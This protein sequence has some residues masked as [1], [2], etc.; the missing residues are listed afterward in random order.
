MQMTISRQ[1]PTGVSTNENQRWQRHL[2]KVD[3]ISQKLAGVANRLVT[4]RL[5]TF[6]ALVTL[7]VSPSDRQL[8]FGFFGEVLI[9]LLVIAFGYQIQRH[10][11]T[12]KKQQYFTY[13][14]DHYHSA[15]KRRKREWH[16]L[17]N[18]AE[19]IDSDNFKDLAVSSE[20]A[21][22]KKL[23]GMI[24]CSDAWQNW[25][26]WLAT[27]VNDDTIKTRQN[28]VKNLRQKRSTLLRFLHASSEYNI[29]DAV[30]S[31]LKNWLN[32]DK[33]HP[34]MGWLFY[35]SIGSVLLFW[36]GLAGFMFKQLPLWV[37][38]TGGVGNGIITFVTFSKTDQL[39]KK[40]EGLTPII[41]SMQARIA[42]IKNSRFDN[43]HLQKLQQPLVS[44]E[45]KA[46]NSLGT[47]QRL[48]M[49]ADLR[50]FGLI[51]LLAQLTLLWNVHVYTGISRWHSKH[52]KH[53]LHSYQCLSE[54]ETLMGVACFALENNEFNYPRQDQSHCQITLDKVGHPLLSHEQ[55]ITNDLHWSE[56]KPLLLISG[57]NMAGKS[58]FMKALGLNVLLSRLGAPVCANK[59]VW[60]KMT[61]KT[62]IKVE[63]SLANGDS[64]F[65]AE[66]KR[67]VNITNSVQTDESKTESLF[68]LCLFDE[69][70]SGTNSHDRTEIFKAI[71]G[72]LEK[73]DT[74]AVFSTH[75]MKLADYAKTHPR[76][77][78]YQ[79]SE[80]YR[81]NDD[82]Y[83]MDFDYR[84]KPGICQQTNAQTL[85]AVLGLAYND[86]TTDDN[87]DKTPP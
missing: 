48:S 1:K 32:S 66:L 17:K 67:L 64:Y 10:K 34:P 18:S 45:N 20:H 26:Q 72:A 19:T 35:L 38:I 41:S 69:I 63:D 5:I 73:Q 82:Q 59:A 12:K 25:S 23:F 81:Q 7:L 74:F 33:A 47:I 53:I 65:M 57:S 68:T 30:R 9:V 80:Q 83:T 36:L 11:K 2:N 27:P 15:L 16:L 3:K 8:Y 60:P 21:S 79:F 62:V 58:T 42:V 54:L 29:S 56:E 70:M 14:R 40:T 37:C 86:A 87:S 31:E 28:A 71:V 44:S 46:I 76:F 43:T 85:L 13:L 39:F 84:L 49:L 51:Y 55:R 4:I 61:V 50:H 22:L 6:I 24:N 52:R 77:D 78:L 75:D